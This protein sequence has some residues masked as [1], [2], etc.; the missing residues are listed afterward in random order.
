MNDKILDI[1]EFN[2]ITD[3][4]KDLAITEPAREKAET[5]RPSSDADKV[6]AQLDQTY[7][8][9]NIL[10]IKGNLPL[11]NFKDVRPSTKRLRIK[12]NLNS[13]E[14]GN[15]LLILT[16]ANDITGFM[17]QI[18]EISLD[19]IS[20]I[21]ARLEIPQDLFN[22]LKKSVDY[23][24]EVLDSASPA[25][26]RI[27]HDIRSNEEEIKSKMDAYTKGNQSKYLSE[28]IVTI[29]DDR[30]VIPVRQEYRAKF[31]GVVHDQ[32][33]SGQTLFIE[34]EGVLNLNNRGQNLLSQERQEVHKILH[35][36]SLLASPEAKSLDTISHA[37]TELDFL[38]AKAKLAKK[39]KATEPKISSDHSFKMLKARHPL[40]DPEKV[41]PNDICLGKK[42]DTMLITGP[43]TGGKTIT[44]K[45]A[46]L[47]QLMAQ[48][49][50]FIPVQEGSSVGVFSQVYADIGDEQSIE[51]SLSTFSSHI[52]DIVYIMKR[53]SEDTLV[54]IDEIGAGTDPEE[55]ASLAI[56]ILDFLRKKQAKIMVTTHYPELKLYGYNRPRTTNASM[57][58]DL[59]TLSPTYH[60]QIGI[61][62]HSNAFAIAR[63][64]GMREDVVKNAQSLMKDTDSDIN[65]MIERLNEQTKAASFARNHLQTSLDRSE[66]LEQKLQ[67]ALDWYNQRVQKQLDFA[68]ERANEVVAKRRKK[69]DQIIKKLEN[70]HRSIK[71]N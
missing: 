25:L 3:Q 8:L 37:L 30:Y 44:L 61:P 53:V 45:T 34:P 1:L 5:L 36:L 52:N 50:L 18:D 9:T 58:F 70:S 4:L 31:G 43:N 2:R 41:V 68:Q 23:D 22:R 39:M 47:L 56:S 67:E 33:A 66:K 28:A 27:R 65:K 7:T 57:E 42:F 71:E 17:D 55:G 12:A 59:K 20:N 15:I 29:R 14:F 48:S 62:G 6:K 32:S 13:K 38:Q 51:Q 69:A 64:L 11:T 49:G 60:L 21:L 24:G 40:I 10:R 35:D 63:R 54:L 26:A 19:S 16:L 46:G